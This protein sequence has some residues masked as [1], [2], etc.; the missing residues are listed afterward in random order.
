MK[1]YK[2][3]NL[4]CPS[5]GYVYPD[6]IEDFVIVIDGKP[7]VNVVSTEECETCYEPIDICNH[8]KFAMGSITYQ[9]LFGSYFDEV[10]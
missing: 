10:I 5:C 3:A 2:S 6:S 7:A 4:K 1:V 8:I 9:T